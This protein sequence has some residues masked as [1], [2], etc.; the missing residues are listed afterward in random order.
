[1]NTN[2]LPTDDLK[3]YGILEEDDSFSKKLSN[4]EIQKFLQGNIMVADNGKNIVSF[5]LINENSN[6]DVKIF[7]RKENLNQILENSKKEVQYSEVK[8]ITEAENSMNIQ[9]KAFIYD[10]KSNSVNE[11]DF[12]KNSTELTKTILDKQNIDESNRYKIE[13]LKLKEFLQEKMD[14]YPEIAKEISNDINI[15]SK[16]INTVNSISADEK[17]VSKSNDSDIKLNVNDNDLYEDANRMREEKE[18]QDRPR[19]FRR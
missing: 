9:K 4:L 3:K 11:Y 6:L 5:Q 2:S 12:I 15:V 19:G 8:D 13:L 7:E 10:E 17:Q 14:K 18:N 1:M 16:E